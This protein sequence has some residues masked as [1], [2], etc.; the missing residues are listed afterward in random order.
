MR[1][2]SAGFVFLTATVAA[3]A[4]FL[5]WGSTQPDLDRVWWRFQEIQTGRIQTLEAEDLDLL[6]ETLTGY[7]ELAPALLDD[8]PA[9]I[10]SAHTSGYLETETAYILVQPGREDPP[11]IIL[12]GR[13]PSDAYPVILVL[14]GPDRKEE[15]RFDE[16]GTI[17]LPAPDEGL[18]ELRG[19]ASG[20]QVRF[21]RSP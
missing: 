3:T 7:P 11:V 16:P 6:R 20:I 8:Q 18:L 15:I 12:D 13:L 1:P 9:G 19:A 4:A 5:A 2:P 17:S 14:S 10:L 21:P